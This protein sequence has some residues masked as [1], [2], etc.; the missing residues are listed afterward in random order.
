M[1]IVKNKEEFNKV[2]K[3]AY[4]SKLAEMKRLKACLPPNRASQ[5][6]QPSTS[7]ST[8]TTTCLGETIDLTQD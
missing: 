4:E 2:Y 8:T 3:L 7:M 1:E 5:T 6:V